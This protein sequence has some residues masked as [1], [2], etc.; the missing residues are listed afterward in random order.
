MS[1]RHATIL[2]AGGGT[3]GHIFPN[4]AIIERL[5]ERGVGVDPYLLISRRPLDARMVAETGW[6]YMS[7][8]AEPLGL[9]PRAL[10]S[11]VRGYRRS[12]RQMREM[13]RQTSARALVA[14]GGFVSAPAITAARSM[15]LPTALVNL[16]AVP[17][18]A[19]RAMAGRA[20]AIFSV[21]PHRS[22]PGAHAIGLP[23]REAA[24]GVVQPDEARVQLGLHP[25][26]PTLLVTAG[27]QGA[28]SIN[29]LM[30]ALG[31]NERARGVMRQWQVLHLAGQRQRDE[32]ERAYAAAGIRARVYGFL[33]RI[34]L[35]WTSASLAISRAGAGSVAEAWANCV[36]TLFLPYPYHKDEHQRHNARPMV[37]TGGAMLLP[38]YVDPDANV[39]Q[40]LDPLLALMADEPRR[41]AMRCALAAAD[42]GDGA[43]AVAQ[44]VVEA[45]GWRT[46]RPAPRDTAGPRVRRLPDADRRA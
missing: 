28:E 3:G 42:P 38:D 22:L 33:D 40:L 43:S 45:L 27:S 36:P 41:Y 8:A 1:A 15:G 17:G 25:D 31:R 44:W 6:P 5:V 37:A 30:V 18:R 13:I 4:L 34:G 19:N 29:A 11:F 16:D 46:G 2:F 12:V 23:L 14:T 21:Y 32:L 26:R 20:R 24:L 10:W 7:L 35:A 9:R 39:E